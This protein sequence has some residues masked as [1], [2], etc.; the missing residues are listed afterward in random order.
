MAPA[1]ANRSSISTSTCSAAAEWI[2]RQGRAGNL[3]ALRC[4]LHA[5]DVDVDVN[6]F[7]AMFSGME[8][9]ARLVAKG[10]SSCSAGWLRQCELTRPETRSRAVD[11]QLLVRK[12][13]ASSLRQRPRLRRR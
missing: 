12:H 5:V 11:V 10:E 8:G 13:V 2:G 1:R 6:E 3:D 9:A 4:P 7:S